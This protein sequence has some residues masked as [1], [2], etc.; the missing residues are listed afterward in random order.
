M[1]VAQDSVA[2]TQQLLDAGLTYGQVRHQLATG[3][4]RWI[5]SNVLL[6]SDVEPTRRQWMWVGV[7]D[8]GPPVAL[9]SHTALEMAGFRGFAEEAHRIHVVAPHGSRCAGGGPLQL[10]ESRRFGAADCYG[11]FRLPRVSPARAAID[12]AAWQPWPRFTYA[13]LAAVVQQRL[14]TVDHLRTELHQA[15]SIRHRAHMRLV[16]DDIAGGAQALSEIDVTRLCRRHGLA[17][18]SRQVRRCDARGRVRWLDCEWTLP[19]GRI[20]VLEVDGSHHMSV[21]HWETDLRRERRVVLDWRTVLRASAGE[22][23]LEGSDL[24][25]DLA[26]AGVPQQR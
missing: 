22:V 8:V 24:A 14:T 20:I 23:R 2:R 21:E 26:A 15:G 10:H 5:T 19:D 4:W 1:Q 12:A 6:C 18:P 17:E 13:V 11:P 16:L 9:A 3:R 25:A 7:L